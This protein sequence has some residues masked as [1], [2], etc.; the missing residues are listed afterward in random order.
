MRLMLILSY[1]YQGKIYLYARWIADKGG[2]RARRDQTLQICIS[3]PTYAEVCMIEYQLYSPKIRRSIDSNS[4]SM[5]SAN[6]LM[7]TN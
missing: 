3:G 2:A 6:S 1:A 4:I 5:Y 7:V